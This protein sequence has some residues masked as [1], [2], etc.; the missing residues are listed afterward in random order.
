M[1]LGALVS[2]GLALAKSLGVAGS[3]TITRTAPG[4]YVAEQDER[5]CDVVTSFTATAT[6]EPDD[7]APDAPPT[8]GTM[9]ARIRYFTLAAD[10][11]AFA[12]AYGMTAVIAPDTKAFRVMNVVPAEIISSLGLTAVAYRV[13]VA[14]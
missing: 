2:S 12:P 10:D 8:G 14:G 4:P 3:V 13:Q 9:P 11:C 5:G 1:N 7:A 6:V